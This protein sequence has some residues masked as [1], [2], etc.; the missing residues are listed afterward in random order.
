MKQRIYNFRLINKQ[1]CLSGLFNFKQ[2][3]MNDKPHKSKSSG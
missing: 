1:N 3:S 2:N